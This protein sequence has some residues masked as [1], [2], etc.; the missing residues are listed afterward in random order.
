MTQRARHS[1]GVEGVS[2]TVLA[3]CF[4]EST[5]IYHRWPLWDTSVAAGDAHRTPE[6]FFEVIPGFGTVLA[7][8]CV[9]K[10][11]KLGPESKAWLRDS[12]DVDPCHA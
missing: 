4:G 2:T 5:Q 3:S 8:S 12:S 9:R 6:V 1:N 11:W 7:L 10:R